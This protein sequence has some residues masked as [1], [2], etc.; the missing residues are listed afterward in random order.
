MRDATYGGPVHFL[1]I[2]KTGGTALAE[3]L[4]PIAQRY[5]II[6]HDHQTKLNQVPADHKVF[7]FVRNPA[8]RFVSGFYS[9]L[10]RGQPRHHYEWS[11][12][13]AKAF[14]TFQK[15]NDLAEGLSSRDPRRRA[16]AEEAMLSIRH[17]NSTYRDWI[18]G[19]P[20]L[21]TRLDSIL[22]IG[23]QETITDDFKRLKILLALPDNISL[24][25]DDV[26]SHRTPSGFDR[27]LSTIAQGNLADWYHDDFVFYEY[28][29][30]LAGA[31]G[32]SSLQAW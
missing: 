28:C 9:R 6:L 1:H 11:D 3:A 19:V 21:N 30:R 27:H 10:R 8:T 25:S 15:A 12:G 16:A 31:R 18:D 26:L 13:E 20:E 24:P 23:T 14:R 2:R 32:L 4:R 5:Q 17:V 22:L 7:F 29:I